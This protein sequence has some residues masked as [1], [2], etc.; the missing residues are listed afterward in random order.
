MSDPTKRRWA[1]G[2]LAALA[3]GSLLVA[4]L[5]AATP[6]TAAPP[7][8]PKAEKGEE[9]H[10]HDFRTPLQEKQDAMRQ[11]ALEKVLAGKATPTG[12]N[13]VVKLA[14]GQYVEL[15]REST[16]RIF[17]VLVEFGDNQYPDPRFQGPPP[18]GSTTDVTGPL[19]NEIPPP[20]RAVDNST[21][22]Q[23]DYNQAHYQD[24]YFNRMAEYYETQSSGRYSV[25]GTVTEWVKVPF[26]EALYGRNYCG[27]IVCNTS[28]ALIR[29]ALAVWVKGQRDAGKTMAEIAAYL[30]T[31]DQQDRYDIERRRRLQRAGRGHRPL[32]DRPRGRRRGRG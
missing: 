21:L 19:H 22:W 26:N 8:K 6:A 2:A 31:F 5:A 3:A 15:A 1:H 14:K 23:A 27:D 16:D 7:T 24:M 28:R 17:T 20:N 9:S 12:K 4:G 29:D 32:P 13:K 18:D 11:K 10:K 30:K 25:D